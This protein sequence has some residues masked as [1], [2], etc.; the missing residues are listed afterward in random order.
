MCLHNENIDIHNWTMAI[1]NWNKDIHNWNI[2]FH[3][4]ILDVHDWIMD[5]PN[6]IIKSPG[7]S[8]VTLCFFAGS[9]A[10]LP[11]P[12]TTDI[13]SRD[14]FWTTFRIP[15]IFGRINDLHL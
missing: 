3:N 12:L 1:H 10:P 15:F 14:N 13:C 5:T 8:G 11:P 4:W 7:I 6:W 9:Y 2:S